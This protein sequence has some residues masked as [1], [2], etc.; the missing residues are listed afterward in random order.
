MTFSHRQTRGIEAANANIIGSAATFWRTGVDMVKQRGPGALYVGIMPRLAYQVPSAVL[1]WWTIGAIERV[2][3]Q[4]AK[5][6]RRQKAL[7]VAPL[8]S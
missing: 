3:G 2:M 7:E 5:E 4:W 6:Q 1:C 8:A